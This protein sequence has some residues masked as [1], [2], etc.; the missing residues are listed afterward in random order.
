MGI[1]Q[2]LNGAVAVLAAMA[3]LSNVVAGLFFIRVQQTYGTVVDVNLPAVSSALNLSA[4]SAELAAGAPALASV[5]TD[6]ER[7]QVFTA[8]TGKQERSEEHTSELQ[9][10]MRISYAVFCLQKKKST[11]E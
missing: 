5:T 11:Q 3:V 2:K 10:L 4:I 9:S 1:R 6:A 8:L 7:E